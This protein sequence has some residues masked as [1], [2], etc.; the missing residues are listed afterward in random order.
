M[1][2]RRRAAPNT[3]AT[4]RHA[5]PLFRAPPFECLKLR[6]SIFEIHHAYASVHFFFATKTH[7]DPNGEV[8]L[9]FSSVFCRTFP[10]FTR[11]RLIVDADID[12]T[13]VNKKKDVKTKN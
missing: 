3:N 6:Q 13:T 12:S 4:P 11:R 2:K 10:F 8:K 1:R 7:V 9:M 5:A